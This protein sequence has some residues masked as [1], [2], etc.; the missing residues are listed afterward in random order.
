MVATGSIKKGE[1]VAE[2][3]RSAILC[4]SNIPN[5]AERIQRDHTFQF[6]STSSW[7]PL[8]LSLALESSQK[9]S[10]LSSVSEV[11]VFVGGV[12]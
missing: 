5:I 4:C 10:S 6:N 2:I 11:V 7:L 12:N 3:P 9:N 1:C 8:L